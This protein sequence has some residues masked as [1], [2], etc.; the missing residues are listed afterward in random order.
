M[1][2]SYQKAFNPSN[3][4]Y[5]ELNKLKEK[6]KKERLIGILLY[7]VAATIIVFLMSIGGEFFIG[8]GVIVLI[9]AGIF[10]FFRVTKSNAE[11]HALFK[12]TVIGPLAHNIITQAELK[13]TG[14]RHEQRISYEPDNKLPKSWLTRSQLFNTSYDDYS[15]EDYFEGQ[16]GL[17]EFKFS[18][19]KLTDTETSTDSD[20]HTTTSTVTVFDGLLFVADFKKDFNGFTVVETCSLGNRKGA[21][22]LIGNV[23]TSLKSSTSLKNAVK[24]QLENEEFNQ[25]FSVRSNDE[26]EARYILSSK[27]IDMLLDFKKSHNYDIAISFSESHMFIAI[28]SRRNFF[29]EGIVKKNGEYNV[30]TV[31]EDLVFLFSIIE[32]FELNNRIWSKQ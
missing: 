4:P 5:D 10:V 6:G 19:V 16:L 1:F 28:S 32:H 2:P 21:A 14:S 9:V 12:R 23:I 30:E 13:Q 18:E 7:I 20:G 11:Y 22:K 3:I 25:T 26:I 29:D 17:T 31:Y 24:V 15:G 8:L 27:M